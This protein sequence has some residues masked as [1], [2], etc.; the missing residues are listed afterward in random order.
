ML[1]GLYKVSVKTW[2]TM[3]GLWNILL[4][5]QIKIRRMMI[6]LSS[7]SSTFVYVQSQLSLLIVIFFLSLTL[8]IHFKMLYKLST[9][10]LCFSRGQLHRWSKSNLLFLLAMNF[11]QLVLT[12][13]YIKLQLADDLIL[14]DYAWC[15][16]IEN[17][18]AV[19]SQ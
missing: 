15:C 3:K 14:S 6:Q 5:F 11:N 2:E 12:H 7:L 4:W 18:I 8:M 1:K 16:S 19:D 9:C 10:H 13:K 17:T